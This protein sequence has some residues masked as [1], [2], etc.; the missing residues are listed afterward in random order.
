MPV[1]AIDPFAEHTDADCVQYMTAYAQKTLRIPRAAWTSGPVAFP[2]GRLR[3]IETVLKGT[4][5][6]LAERGW[7]L[8]D[9]LTSQAVRRPMGRLAQGS[10]QLMAYSLST[11]WPVVVDV[12]RAPERAAPTSRRVRM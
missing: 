2:A 12:V 11:V 3:M 7:T 9:R 6:N 4:R 5:L 1:Y 10:A 8:H